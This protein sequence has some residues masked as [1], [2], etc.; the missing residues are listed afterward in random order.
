MS[1]LSCYRMLPYAHNSHMTLSGGGRVHLS[2]RTSTSSRLTD[3]A[4]LLPWAYLASEDRNEISASH[5][6]LPSAGFLLSEADG[7][8][9]SP[10]PGVH[11]GTS[12][13]EQAESESHSQAPSAISTSPPTEPRTPAI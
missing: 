8:M 1:D 2:N 3:L 13:R 5:F 11:M 12:L 9:P 7:G 6:T 10:W 4:G